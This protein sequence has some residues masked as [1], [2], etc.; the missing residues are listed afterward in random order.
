MRRSDTAD[1]EAERR[2]II[3]LHQNGNTDTYET[4]LKAKN[5]EEAAGFARDKL[6]LKDALGGVN[7]WISDAI[8]YNPAGEK[9]SVSLYSK[10]RDLPKA[11]DKDA[12]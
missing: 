10:E 11:A 7:N 6:W 9:I 5:D 8:L 3:L 4:S 1:Q 12:K 2:E